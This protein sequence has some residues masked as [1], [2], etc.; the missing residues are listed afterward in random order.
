V[1]NGQH[2]QP[3]MVILRLNCSCGI[4]FHQEVDPPTLSFAT[5]IKGIHHD[6]INTETILGRAMDRYIAVW[7][8]W[9]RVLEWWWRRIV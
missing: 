5:R 2:A 9:G 3:L 6:A 1:S 4:P 7:L 8:R